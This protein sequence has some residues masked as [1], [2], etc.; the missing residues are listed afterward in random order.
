MAPL[1][2]KGWQAGEIVLNGG[3]SGMLSQT[4]Q[5]LADSLFDLFGIIILKG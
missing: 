1:R 2:Q 4:C 3:G 5:L